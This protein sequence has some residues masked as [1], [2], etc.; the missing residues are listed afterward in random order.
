VGYDPKDVKVAKLLVNKKYA[1]IVALKKRL[2]LPSI[3]YPLT[4]GMVE[5]EQRK[6]DMLNLIIEQNIQLKKMEEKIEELLKEKEASTLAM[7]PLT[8]V[9]IEVVGIEPSSSSTIIESTSI[10][11]YLVI[12][13]QEL[14][15]QK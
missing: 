8:T 14:S 4:K 3:E 10:T 12:L 9:P 7:V 5:N 13:S 1:D 11:T 6:E 2:K 15:I